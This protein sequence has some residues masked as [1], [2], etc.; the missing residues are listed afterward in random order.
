VIEPARSDARYLSVSGSGDLSLAVERRHRLARDVSPGT[1][2]IHNMKAPE[3]ATSNLRD[4]FF[5]KNV[6]L[7]EI[8]LVFIQ[9]RDIF[10]AKRLLAMMLRLPLDVTT[11]FVDL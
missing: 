4:V 9:E 11:N 3:G 8:N 6:S 7:I 1:T 2:S 10:L 5:F